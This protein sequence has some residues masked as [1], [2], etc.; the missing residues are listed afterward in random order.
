MNIVNTNYKLVVCQLISLMFDAARICSSFPRD[1]LW[2]WLNRESTRVPGGE[3]AFKLLDLFACGWTL[4][5]TGSF[6]LDYRQRI[7]R[8]PYSW[9]IGRAGGLPADR[10][11]RLQ[12]DQ[13]GS[14]A[15]LIG[16]RQERATD[17]KAR[18]RCA[19]YPSPSLAG[20]RP[21]SCPRRV[22]HQ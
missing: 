14:R 3:S 13:V 15:G 2:R 6:C 10:H 11:S 20:A 8:T 5:A 17:S 12:M 21:H 4:I 19:L 7:G 18:N 9:G 1:R 16:A 22:A